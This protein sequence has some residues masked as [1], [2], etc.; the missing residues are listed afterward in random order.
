MIED[1]NNFHTVFHHHSVEIAKILSHT[2]SQKF[3]ESID[4][5]KEITK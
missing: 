4:F 2:F 3:R 5:S 1:S